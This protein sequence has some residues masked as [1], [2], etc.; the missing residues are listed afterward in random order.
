M[1]RWFRRATA[2]SSVA[3]LALSRRERPGRSA[4]RARRK[5][6][7]I[8][9]ED[10]GDERGASRDEGPHDARPF[11]RGDVMEAVVQEAL[12]GGEEQ[13]RRE[14]APHGATIAPGDEG[15]HPGP[16]RAA[17]E[18]E[19]GREDWHERQRAEPAAERGERS[20][21][22]DVERIAEEREGAADEDAAVTM[23][24]TCRDHESDRGR[25]PGSGAS[26]CQS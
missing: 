18:V 4:R 7:S 23:V 14:D 25:A 8:R 3:R 19:D 21:E 13:R 26:T 10:E 16:L 11:Q 22:H 24:R 20:L 9:G 15:A 5:A 2:S 1:P 17:R 6:A 12:E